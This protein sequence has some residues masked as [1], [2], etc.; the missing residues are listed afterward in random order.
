[1]TRNVGLRLPAMQKARLRRAV[2]FFNQYNTHSQIPTGTKNGTHVSMRLL[3][4][5]T[6][7]YDTHFFYL[8]NLHI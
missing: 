6:H 4:N 5:N 8:R 2:R 1:M 7:V 3:Q